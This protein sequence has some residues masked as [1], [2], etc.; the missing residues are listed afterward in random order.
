MV[1][2]TLSDTDDD[3]ALP[4]GATGVD[5]TLAVT[6]ATVAGYDK[7]QLSDTASRCK[8]AATSSVSTSPSRSSV[9]TPV[10]SGNKVQSEVHLASPC[11]EGHNQAIRLKE[12]VQALG[13]PDRKLSQSRSLSED[14]DTLVLGERAS[15]LRQQG[16]VT[17][18]CSNEPRSESKH[19][20]G[21]K[22]HGK[23]TEAAQENRGQLQLQTL[24][25]SA[26]V[27]GSNSPSVL[28]KSLGNHS[29]V[30]SAAGPL[31]ALE[32]GGYHLIS[33]VES[34]S[35]STCTPALSMGYHMLISCV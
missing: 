27:R 21:P 18:K 29:A 11:F 6:S 8:D 35:L 2:L 5:K 19:N 1:D 31:V 22:S 30:N 3:Y 10:L 16:K 17:L 9:S 14:T 25:N 15:V 34:S 4:I 26:G 7:R 20:K 13:R 24:N 12:N 23:P 33:L 32:V 28:R